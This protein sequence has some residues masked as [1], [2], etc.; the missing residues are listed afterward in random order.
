MSDSRPPPSRLS[1]DRSTLPKALDQE[2]RNGNLCE[3]A[4]V[5]RQQDQ[6][7]RSKSLDGLRPVSEVLGLL[8]LGSGIQPPSPSLAEA[9]DGAVY[10]V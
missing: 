7:S 5:T 8:Y 3:G 1:T 10:G 4:K 2:P 9:G 6:I